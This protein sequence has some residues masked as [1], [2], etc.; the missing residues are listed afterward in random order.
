M[1]M[2]LPRLLDEL[3]DGMAGIERSPQEIDAALDALE[4]IHMVCLRGESPAPGVA[5]SAAA[6]A[7][8]TK[9]A[10]EVADM[11]RAIQQDMSGSE[12]ALLTEGAPEDEFVTATDEAA[13]V[14]DEPEDE[15][16]AMAADMALGTWLEFDID[17]RKRRAKLA[18]KSAVMGEYVFV[19]RKYKVVAER[20]LASLAAD[21]RHGRTTLVEDLPMFDRAL[22]KVLNGLMSGG[23]TAH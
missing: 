16:T 13:Q 22:D 14:P 1:V 7:T 20:S 6:T 10:D 3:R 9:P 17:D 18:W 8:G 2:L 15:F 21:L 11:I 23:K 12:D 5:R 19:D 4:P